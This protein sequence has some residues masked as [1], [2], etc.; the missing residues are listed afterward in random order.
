MRVLIEVGDV[1]ILEPDDLTTLSVVTELLQTDAGAELRR[2]GLGDIAD[3]SAWLDIA[4]LHRLAAAQSSTPAWEQSWQK[5][6]Q[7]A[8]TAGWVNPGG[9]AVEAHVERR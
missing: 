4:T 2:S 7:F 3:D 5:M 1:R 9:D 6:I 8:G